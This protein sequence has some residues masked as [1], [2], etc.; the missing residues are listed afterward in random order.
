LATMNNMSGPGAM[1][2]TN[3]AAMNAPTNA[4]S[5]NGC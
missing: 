2:S 4:G 5:M 3:T 1:L